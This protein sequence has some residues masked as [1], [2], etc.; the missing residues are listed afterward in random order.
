MVSYRG[1]VCYFQILIT[2]LFTLS[3]RYG[4][5]EGS[6]SEKG[7]VALHVIYTIVHVDTFSVLFTG[8]KL[9]AQ[10]ALDYV[11][12]HPILSQGQTVRE[13]WLGA[14]RETSLTPHLQMLYGQS[15][16]GAVSI[17]LASRNPLAVRASRILS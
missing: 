13:Y 8:I 2:F 12:S 4:L 9:D 14:I 6:P 11:R 10:S 3:I 5:S 7:L 15:I 17:D 1:L 16:G